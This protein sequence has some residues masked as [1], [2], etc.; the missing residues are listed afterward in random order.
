VLDWA[1]GLLKAHPN[2]RGIVASHYLVGTGNPAAFGSQGQSIYD[3]LKDNPNLFLL[4]CGHICG[5][6]QRSDAFN[7]RTVRSILTDYQCRANGGNG[8]LRTMTFSPASDT[9]SFKT[10]SPTLNQ[11]ETDADSQFTLPYDM[12]GTTPAAFTQIGSLSAVPVGTTA[13]VTWS[14]LAAATTYEWYV[15]ASDAEHTVPTATRTF[16]T[17]P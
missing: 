2:R 16:T 12:P 7:G 13:S 4:L 10:Y 15:E 1:D 14:N 11:Y 8:W 9:I 17:A 5:E 3:S 6:G